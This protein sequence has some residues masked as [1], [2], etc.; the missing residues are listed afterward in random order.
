MSLT[1]NPLAEPR[2]TS[3]A[4]AVDR[5]AR[6]HWVHDPVARSTDLP[7]HRLPGHRLR[8]GHP[9]GPI[10]FSLGALFEPAQHITDGQA[11]I[12][13][14]AAADPITNGL[15]IAGFVLD[16]FLLPISVLGMA[17]LAM[18]G[19]PWLATIGG[20]LGLL[21]WAP[22]AA[23]AAQDD[24]TR[25]MA[26]LGSSELLGRLWERFNNDATMTLFLVVYIVGHLLAYVVLAIALRRAGVIPSWAAWVLASTTPLTLAFFATRLRVEVLGFAFLVIFCAAFIVSSA[27]VARAALAA[28]DPMDRE[29]RHGPRLRM[30]ERSSAA[31]GA[32]IARPVR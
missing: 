4:D 10:A 18:N 28:C 16:A 14:N 19:S 31:G 26:R 23:L 21:G 25:Q 3:Q 24:L 6:T 12:A 20:T 8:G 9:A 32:S 15:H 1:T 30:H 11:A 29:R 2:I 13:A 27:A 5:P 7:R 17:R 22:F